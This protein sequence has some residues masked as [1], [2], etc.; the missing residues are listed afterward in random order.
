MKILYGV[1]GTGNGHITRAGTLAKAFKEQ[2]LDVQFLVS[3]RPKLELFDMEPFGDYWWR[4]GLTFRSRKGRILLSET[5]VRSKPF[6]LAQDVRG[7]DVSDFDLIITDYEPITAWA[8][9]L[10]GT[11][12]LG[13]GHQYAFA[14]DIPKINMSLSERVIFQ[15]YAPADYSLGLH[16]YHFEEPLLPPI[17]PVEDITLPSLGDFTLVYLP[18]ESADQVQNL[19]YKFRD[20]QFVV[21]HPNAPRKK[22]GNAIWC[23]PS[24][25]TFSNDLH[26]CQGVICNAG[27]ELASE[28][29]QLGKKILVKPLNKQVEQYCNALALEKLGWGSTMESLDAIK[30]STWLNDVFS[31]KIKYPD[32]AAAVA[33]YIREGNFKSCAELASDLWSKTRLPDQS[34]SI[35]AVAA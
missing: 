16:W 22:I 20:Q 9:R 11:P 21:Y 15:N 3:G 4:E 13:I 24:R 28:A 26:R 18:F 19:L 6:Q 25:V 30:V 14:Y 10:S 32:T 27:F 34:I 7:L 8:G 35:E 17:A 12:T 33:R 5:I 1:Q 2:G 31:V 23:Q 29:L